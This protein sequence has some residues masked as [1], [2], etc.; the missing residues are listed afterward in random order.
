[1]SVAPSDVRDRIERLGIIPIVRTETRELA[2]RAAEALVLGGADVVE[3]TLG[4]PDAAGLIQELDVRFGAS[5]TIGAGTVLSVE[6]ARV[7]LDAG[8]RFLVAPTFDAAVVRFARERD[9]AIVPG[10]LTPSEVAA[11]WAGGATLVKVFPCS[12]L[13]GP[14]YL[15]ALREVLPEVRLVPTGGVTLENLAAYLEAGACAFG[16]AGE[17]LDRAALLA[18]YTQRISEKTALFLATLAR[19]RAARQYMR[20]VAPEVPAG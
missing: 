10:A 20:G 16:V 9:V 17:L 12:A 14:G 5:V 19:V 8:A 11:A 15:A 4:V 2:R 1:M 18:G 7:C 6:D 3:I 13:G